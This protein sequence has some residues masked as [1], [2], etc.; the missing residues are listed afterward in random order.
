MKRDAVTL[1]MELDKNQDTLRSCGIG[2]CRQ[3]QTPRQV[4]ERHC[5]AYREERCTG[6]KTPGDGGP[7]LMTVKG[8][9]VEGQSAQ[10]L[11]WIGSQ[12]FSTDLMPGVEPFPLL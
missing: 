9:L 7:T 2:I 10:L 11:Q 8:N 12:E 6:I 4:T 3:N 5:G 1:E